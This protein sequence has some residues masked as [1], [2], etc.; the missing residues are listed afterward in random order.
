MVSDPLGPLQSYRCNEFGHL[1]GGKHPPR[2]M[3]ADLSGTCTS[4]EDGVLIRVADTVKAIKNLKADPSKVFVSVIAAPP[5]PYV[6]AL[7]P[8][9]VK[10]DPSQWP[11]VQHSCMAAD[12]SYGD[13]AV[14]LNLLTT[15]FGANGIFEDVCAGSFV[16]ALTAAASQV[17]RAILPPCLDAAVD[18]AKCSA[19][20]HVVDPDSGN[21]K[22]APLARCSSNAAQP[23]CWDFGAPQSCG[24][25]RTLTLMTAPPV[26]DESVTLTCSK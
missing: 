5:T 7:G 16:T 4:A 18:P 21:V 15:S 26:T 8:A 23:P 13:P 19:V 22:S 1:C 12:G 6:V 3:A 17:G 25:G 10:N 14:R 20:L 11:Y 9:Q 2:T 24:Q